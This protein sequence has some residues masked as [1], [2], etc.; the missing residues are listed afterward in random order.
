[1]KCNKAQE[2]ISLELDGQLAPEHVPCLQDHLETCDDCRGYRADL[3][4]GL[5]MLQATE[6]ELPENFDWK[7][8][9]RLSQTLR[10]ATR[11]AAY[12]WQQ[13]EHG[14][15]RWFTRAGFSAALGMAAV[16]AISLL[17]PQALTPGLVATGGT[18][19]ALETMRIP[20][21]DTQANAVGG[22][23]DPSRRPLETEFE[24]NL[25][26]FAAGLQ[27]R[28]SSNGGFGS[29]Y[30]SGTNERD[31]LRIRHLEQENESLRRRLS[32]RERHLEV[33]KAKLD[34]LTGQPL[35]NH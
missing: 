19:A 11:D 2:W 16:L 10:E 23:F 6:P 7:L 9:L 28:V 22:L 31:L 15:R 27:R 3:Q 12:P 30:W 21:Q 1:M 25:D 4:L 34:S 32:I 18:P 26:P 29:A 14:W 8:Q 17:V 20:V 33:L 35:D 5:R 13:V 24:R